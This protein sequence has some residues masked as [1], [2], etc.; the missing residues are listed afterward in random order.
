MGSVNRFCSI[1]KWILISRSVR[2]LAGVLIQGAG[3]ILESK[4]MN[5][6]FEEIGAHLE[7]KLVFSKKAA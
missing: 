4:I 2:P 1:K 3:G 6:A 5:K 7:M